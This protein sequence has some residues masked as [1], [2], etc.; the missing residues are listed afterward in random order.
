MPLYGLYSVYVELTE[1]VNIELFRKGRYSIR[2]RIVGDERKYVV[3]CTPLEPQR[4]LS[5]GD[6]AGDGCFPGTGTID[7]DARSATCTTRS[8]QIHFKQQRAH[9]DTAFQCNIAVPFA[10]IT[11]TDAL[12]TL[13]I[14]LL[15][16]TED[17]TPPATL[18][19]RTLSVWSQ[20]CPARSFAQTLEFDFLH[21][22]S[23]RMRV[24][25]HFV[26]VTIKLPRQL[27]TETCTIATRQQIQQHRILQ[28]ILETNFVDLT[29]PV[30]VRKP[31]EAAVLDL[32]STLG[33]GFSST[34]ADI[35]HHAH[36][37][38]TRVLEASAMV[39][40]LTAPPE[41]PDRLGVILSRVTSVLEV[42]QVMEDLE[43]R[44]CSM[45]AF[46]DSILNRI[47]QRTDAI[48]IKHLKTGVFVDRPR[49]GSLLAHTDASF[50]GE[51]VPSLKQLI[52]T[53]Q[54]VL[55]PQDKYQMFLL[56]EEMYLPSESATVF[57]QELRLRPESQPPSRP[58]S[59]DTSFYQHNGG[60]CSPLATSPVLSRKTSVSGLG[61]DALVT[62]VED[63]DSDE[64]HDVFSTAESTDADGEV[65]LQF[66]ASPAAAAVHHERT[67]SYAG[68]NPGTR[69]TTPAGVGRADSRRRR[70]GLGL[71]AKSCDSC[72]AVEVMEV[73]Q[74]DLTDLRDGL[75]IAVRDHSDSSSELD[76]D[77]CLHASVFNSLP[78]LVR[79]LASSQY[80]E[81]YPEAAIQNLSDQGHGHVFV[82]VHGLNG[83][84]YDLRTFKLEIARIMPSAK[85]VM[86]DSLE[87]LTHASIQVQAN[88]LVVELVEK[89]RDCRNATHVSFVA[90]SLGNVVSRCA[91]Q[92]PRL[93]KLFG[94]LTPGI[95]SEEELKAHAA[96]VDPLASILSG[97]TAQQQ[98]NPLTLHTFVS[99]C[100]PHLGTLELGGM[101]TT[102]MWFLSK[103]RKSKS[104]PQLN[105]KDGRSA[106]D[107][108]L[109][110]LSSADS[111]AH[112]NNVVLVA[113]PQDGYSSLAS[114]LL[115]P[116]SAG[117]AGSSRRGVCDDM[118]RNL[119]R[120][121]TRANLVR[122]QTLFPAERPSLSGFIGRKA[123]INVLD[124]KPFVR[125][126]VLTHYHLLVRADTC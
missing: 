86:V 100:A 55:L 85:F 123:H 115:T 60:I 17:S 16:E 14:S 34:L 59:R 92:D 81:I 64:E 27:R 4:Q 26:G 19:K 11:T 21:M 53:H 95:F 30:S 46:H 61:A 68:S 91:L 126:F 18:F 5:L 8:V 124:A 84:R 25:A 78:P 113:S 69:P 94:V 96:S 75:S 24:H 112:F 66:D 99:L 105:L 42:M 39:G 93:R 111:L 54:E 40:E 117:S 43:S 71:L 107:S 82:C 88:A 50:L 121:L 10:S 87:S 2:G 47:E 22:C 73:T 41:V 72:R 103:W 74:T 106:Q 67:A 70:R 45:T 62:I 125:K 108:L 118:R 9:L 52:G 12:C 114:A 104:I 116:P 122:T 36:A 44:F 77:S 97:A 32:F 49:I 76:V 58:A 31:F 120:S 20:P 38:T 1:F 6:L 37:L 56:D 51:P 79:T 65:H 110:R 102:G 119:L 57:I 83:C 48:I 13:E 28:D 3:S 29:D 101:V 35:E 15:C 33:A 109:Y 90:H 80:E 98:A 7:H 23:V 89:L 63:S